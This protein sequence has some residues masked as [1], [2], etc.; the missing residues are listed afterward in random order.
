MTDKVADP[1]GFAHEKTEA[2]SR[3]LLL[4]VGGQPYSYGRNGRAGASAAT[5]TA[6]A[7]RAF[8]DRR[9]LP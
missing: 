9:E 2:A 5:A 7:A 1:D 4:G 3:A 8:S 6:A